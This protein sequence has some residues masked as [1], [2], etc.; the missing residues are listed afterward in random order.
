MSMTIRVV[1]FCCCHVALMAN[2]PSLGGYFVPKNIYSCA[3]PELAI[4]N[5]AEKSQVVYIY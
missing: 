2:S 4:Y 1:S 3:P 5:L